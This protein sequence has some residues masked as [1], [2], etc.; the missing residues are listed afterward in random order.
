MLCVVAPA[1]LRILA[2]QGVTKSTGGPGT[3]K[4]RV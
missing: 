2:I 4:R 1:R 3:E